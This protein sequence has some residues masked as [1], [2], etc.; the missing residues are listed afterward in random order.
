MNDFRVPLDDIRFLLREVLDGEA[1]LQHL[2]ASD[3]LSLETVESVLEEAARLA[4]AELAPLNAIGDQHGCRMLADGTVVTPPGFGAAYRKIAE[5]GW[6][7][8]GLS[9]DCGGAGM[10]AFV[11]LLVTE[12]FGAA[13][14]SL[15]DYAGL[16][17]S[18]ADLLHR[19]ATP[20]LAHLYVPQLL[21]GAWTATMCM[22]EPHCGTDIGLLR[23]R[24]TPDPDGSYRI[25]GTKIFISGGDHDFA[26]NIVHLVLARLPDA[27]PG[28]K[29]VSLFLVP[30]F[31]PAAD[32]KPGS[33]NAVRAVRVEHKMGYAGSATC[34]MQFEGAIGWLIG[35]PN[36]GL[37]PMFGMINEARLTVAL[38][39]VA[40]AEAGYQK[41]LAYA[42]ERRQGR[43]PGGVESPDQPADR[44][45]AHPDVRRMLLEVESFVQAAR[46]VAV[47]L[48]MTLDAARRDPDAARRVAAERRVALLTPVA[49]ATFTDLGFD[50]ANLCLQVFGGH[51]YVRDHGVEQLVRDVR[52]S[53]IQEGANGIQALDLV[54]RKLAPDDG[55]ALTALLDELK[56][57]LDALRPPPELVH[58]ADEVD[59]AI[60]QLR[61]AAE[62]LV[63]VVRSTPMEAAAAAVDFERA[64]GL[65]LLA[66]MLVRMAGRAGG[67]TARG[68]KMTALAR[69]FCTRVLPFAAAHL[70]VAASGAQVVMALPADHF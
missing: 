32:G 50:A 24:A 4:E 53:Q 6:L 10:P 41:A 45:I 23:T 39:G 7:G 40:A 17:S 47:W 63:R 33:R 52:I 5:G 16:T 70:R 31:V 60:A 34:Q 68:R 35:E 44:L 20:A 64:L 28:V 49:K 62:N 54:F 59:A 3:E 26:G 36:R 1:V 66:W 29:G 65:T 38:Q 57:V 42:L 8:L 13:N 51:G 21:S 48:A 22:T 61:P 37:K 69:F 19:H 58:A 11:N 67:D 14:L 30:K 18:G 25:D 12:M 55:A 15:Q 27:P 46:G 56:A 43:S 9:P 2:Y